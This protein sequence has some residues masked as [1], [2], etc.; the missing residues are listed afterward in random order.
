MGTVMRGLFPLEAMASNTNMYIAARQHS[1]STIC[2]CP[3][4][5]RAVGG[6]IYTVHVELW[7]NCLYTAHSHIVM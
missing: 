5:S 1:P 7:K 4:A 6:L 3:V 2:N